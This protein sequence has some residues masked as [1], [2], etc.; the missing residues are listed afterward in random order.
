MESGSWVLVPPVTLGC[1]PHFCVLFVSRAWDQDGQGQM[2]NELGGFVPPLDGAL[3]A[4]LTPHL[5]LSVALSV[6]LH[7]AEVLGA[8]LSRF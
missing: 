5:C 4:A 1:S 3:D 8:P 7:T 6:S 2:C